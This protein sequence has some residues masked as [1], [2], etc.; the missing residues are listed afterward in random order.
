MAESAMRPRLSPWPILIGALAALASVLLAYDLSHRHPTPAAQ[1]VIAGKARGE[2]DV[3]QA[4]EDQNLQ[5]DEETAGTMWAKAHPQ[6]PC[7]SQPRSFHQGCESAP[8]PQ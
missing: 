4:S 2:L 1:A 8:S 6:E 3:A 7:P 5:D